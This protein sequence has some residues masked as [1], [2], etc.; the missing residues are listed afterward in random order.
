MQKLKHF[1][2][3][4]LLKKLAESLV[5]SRLD[6]CDSVYSPFPGYLLKRLPKTDFAAASFVY[7]KYVNDVGDI[8][9]LIRPS[10][11]RIEKA[12]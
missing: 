6:Y 5:L 12:F 1:T 2:D 4:H 10:V 8:L 3:F 9:K 7:G 11:E